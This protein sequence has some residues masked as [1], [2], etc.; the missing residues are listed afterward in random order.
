[1]LVDADLVI[2]PG[3]RRGQHGDGHD[4]RP[5]DPNAADNTSTFTA[6][7][8]AQADLSIRKTAPAGSPI[9]GD[10]SPATAGR[11]HV[12]PRDRQLR[13]VGRARTS[14]FTDMLPPGMTFVPRSTT[15]TTRTSTSRRS[16]T[17]TVTGTP[18]TGR[19]VL[20][21]AR[22]RLPG[23]R[24]HLLRHRVRGRPDRARRDRAGEHGD[25]RRPTPTT[26]T[27]ATT[28]PRALVPVRAEVNLRGREAGG[29]DGRQRQLRCDPAG[30]VA[31]GRRS[32]RRPARP[33]RQLRRR[34]SPTTGPSA[35]ADVQFID[36]FPLDAD[37]TSR[38][39]TAT[40]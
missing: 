39:A 9:A 36:A 27:R 26:A 38:S 16:S 4:A 14:T 20:V 18:E 29:R 34:R 33:R 2:D 1:M 19:R 15:S 25:G 17:A 21:H 5:T 24:R 28:P 37:A 23:V 11:P 6:S 8:G 31:R 35:A 40:S 22:L 7:G 30:A 13:T 32:A 3:R 10:T 12:P